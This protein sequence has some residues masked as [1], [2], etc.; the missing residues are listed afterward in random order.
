MS[1]KRPTANGLNDD[2][3][4]VKEEREEYGEFRVESKNEDVENLMVSDSISKHDEKLI[5]LNQSVSA[6][7]ET[8]V[9]KNP[10]CILSPIFAEYEK[11]LAE[12]E[13]EKEQEQVSDLAK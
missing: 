4:D 3:W 7:I 6:W 8:N 13:K 5:K 1:S 9:D 11:C 10:F 12:L 2:N